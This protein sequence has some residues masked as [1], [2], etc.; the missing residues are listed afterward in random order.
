MSYAQIAEKLG[1]PESQLLQWIEFGEQLGDESIYADLVE[2]IRKAEAE[3][4]IRFSQSIQ[5]TAKYGSYEKVVESTVDAEGNKTTVTI[6]TWSPPDAHLAL[7]MLELLD[8]Q[9][10]A[11]VKRV[12]ISWKD[13]EAPTDA[14]DDDLKAQLE[15]VIKKNTV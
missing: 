8:P 13:D 4:M 10:W 7:R 3:Q 14:S 12:I 15:S 9:R 5:N 1:I 6:Q 2:G 11:E